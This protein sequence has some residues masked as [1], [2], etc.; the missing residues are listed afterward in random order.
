MAV[1]HFAVPC[2]NPDV[3]D[4][5]L[6]RLKKEEGKEFWCNAH[7]RILSPIE[8]DCVVV[9]AK[10]NGLVEVLKIMGL[11]ATDVHDIGPTNV[12][13]C[14][15]LVNK[16]DPRFVGMSSHTKSGGL[17]ED[18]EREFQ[19]IQARHSPVVP[20][21]PPSKS[22]A[23]AKIKRT[24]RDEFLAATVSD[25]VPQQ[26]A[27][28]ARAREA[29]RSFRKKCMADGIKGRELFSRF[30]FLSAAQGHLQE[31]IAQEISALGALG[32]EFAGNKSA[33]G[34]SFDTPSG[35]KRLLVDAKGGAR[36]TDASEAIHD[37]PADVFRALTGFVA[38]QQ[39]HDAVLLLIGFFEGEESVGTP[40]AGLVDMRPFVQVLCG[41]LLRERDA[42]SGQAESAHESREALAENLAQALI[43]YR[44]R[45][46]ELA[47][48]VRGAVEL[49]E[50]RE[51]E[52]DTMVTHPSVENVTVKSGQLVVTTRAITVEYEDP[53]LHEKMRYGVGRWQVKIALSDMAVHVFPADGQ[54]RDGTMIHPHV[55][56]VDTP[57]MKAKANEVCWGA[58]L[59]DVQ[60]AVRLREFKLLLEYVLMLLG[61]CNPSDP[62]SM[63]ALKSIGTPVP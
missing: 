59:T 22:P 4:R 60:E 32:V 10:G 49:R 30:E 47:E 19:R 51:R 34:F 40:P 44:N 52:F 35:K 62:R 29:V 53:Q 31:H 11:K 57:Q 20:F 36:V 46:R 24:P 6:K 2:D 38:R 12:E 25:V 7:F 18:V 1:E 3:V 33:L 56:N 55:Y 8:I 21:V 50:R 28:T 39:F 61:S 54:E 63:I 16:K 23:A 13:G 26:E 41:P 5:E 9:K 14:S 48:T 17:D 42:T 27:A 43:D 37:L 58:L 15:L 45:T